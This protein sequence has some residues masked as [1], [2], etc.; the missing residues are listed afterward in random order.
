MK[1][2]DQ[3]PIYQCSV[4]GHKAKT[5]GAKCPSCN[6]WNTFSIQQTKA[7]KEK[8]ARIMFL[9]LVLIPIGLLCTIWMWRKHGFAYGLLTAVFYGVCAYFKFFFKK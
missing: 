7:Q 4:C 6:R 1:E 9:V 2:N 3:S 8:E 5:W